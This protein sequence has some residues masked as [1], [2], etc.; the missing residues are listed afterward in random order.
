[1][2]VSKN[3]L[4]AQLSAEQKQIS[5]GRLK[6]ESPL[7]NSELFTELCE[8]CRLGDIRR[9]MELIGQGAN[10]NARDQFDYTPL[11]LVR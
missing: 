10:I 9:C 3:K 5:D 8:A 7:D 4:S 11:I 6:D 1:M 2:I